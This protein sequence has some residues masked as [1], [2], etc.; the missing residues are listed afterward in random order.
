MAS[1]ITFL[2]TKDQYE[3]GGSTSWTKYHDMENLSLAADILYGVT[4]ALAV[5]TI[6]LG[7][8]AFR[9]SAEGPDEA[10]LTVSPWLDAPGLTLQGV[11]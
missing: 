8:L 2:N 10:A 7:V 3:K 9:K 5:G 4:G 6:V 11:F 1:G